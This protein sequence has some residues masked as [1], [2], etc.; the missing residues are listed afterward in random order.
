VDGLNEHHRCDQTWPGIAVDDLMLDML[1]A[2][3]EPAID[4]LG[5]LL[6]AWLSEIEDDGG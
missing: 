5:A 3:H 4:R 6:L 1:A 2:G